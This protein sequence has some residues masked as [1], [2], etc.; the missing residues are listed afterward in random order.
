MIAAG[1]DLPEGAVV[2]TPVSHVDFHPT[3]LEAAGL[4]LRDA[5]GALPGESLIGIAK[6]RVPERTVLS[7]YHDGGAVTGMFM[8]RHERF[9]Y[10]HY[11]RLRAGALRLRS[12]P[13][14]AARSR[15]VDRAR[16]DPGRVRGEV[17][18]AARPRRGERPG[19]CGSAPAPRG[20][21][22][23]GGDPRERRLRQRVG[24]HPSARIPRPRL[25]RTRAS[26]RIQAGH[27]GRSALQGLLHERSAVAGDD[28]SQGV[29]REHDLP[30]PRGTCPASATPD[31]GSLP[32][33]HRAL[34]LHGD[35]VQVVVLLVAHGR[36]E[37]S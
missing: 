32:A 23:R 14:R 25:S 4:P 33:R 24:L 22:R 16:T 6:G 13:R 21:G 34:H 29:I 11:P 12:R 35:D 17:A 19:L 8:I 36:G 31:P 27:S 3:I 15:H 5:D 30:H 28:S 18:R 37:V 1:P 2:G 7:E 20:A 9:K 26:V 10:V